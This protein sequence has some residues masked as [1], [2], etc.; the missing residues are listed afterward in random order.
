MGWEAAPPNP[1]LRP[2]HR[3]PRSSAPF[4]R[5]WQAA[6]AALVVVAEQAA[7]FRT[8]MELSERC[9][10]WGC[11]VSPPC[12]PPSYFPQADTAAPARAPTR[13]PESS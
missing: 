10:V 5:L 13:G 11:P 1:E 3:P 2:L 4:S 9:V 7:E 8:V 6:V 12:P